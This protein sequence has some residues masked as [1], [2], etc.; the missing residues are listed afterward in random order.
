MTIPIT[1]Y[2]I[3][4]RRLSPFC[5]HTSMIGEQKSTTP[6]INIV[7][8]HIAIESCGIHVAIEAARKLLSR[9]LLHLKRRTLVCDASRTGAA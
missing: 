1:V 8:L 2:D 7:S 3:S 5:L 6:V 4:T 9:I